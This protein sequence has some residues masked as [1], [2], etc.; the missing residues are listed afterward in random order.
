MKGY[1]RP[2]VLELEDLA[3]GIYAASGEESNENFDGGDNG[4]DNGG[5]NGGEVEGE[6]YTTTVELKESQ[7]QNPSEHYKIYEI[8]AIHH[9]VKHISSHQE[10]EVVFSGTITGVSCQGFQCNQVGNTVYIQRSDNMADAYGSGDR[11][12][13]NVRFDL[14]LDDSAALFDVVGA[15]THC[16][17]AENVHGEND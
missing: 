3:E 7:L 14:P 15:V 10:F 1:V 4:G 9:S 8:C 13:V 12:T 17:H 6:C 16:T 5:N 11:I 2:M